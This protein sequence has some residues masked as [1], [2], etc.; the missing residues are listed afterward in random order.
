[1]LLHGIFLYFF[2]IGIFLYLFGGKAGHREIK[3][4]LQRF[5]FGNWEKI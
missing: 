2:V 1:M 3:I 5:H 4:W